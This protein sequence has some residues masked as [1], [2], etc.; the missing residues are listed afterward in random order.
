LGRGAG[1]GQGSI[2]HTETYWEGRAGF[3]SAH[4]RVFGMASISI[5]IITHISIGFL[6]GMMLAGFMVG[7]CVAP[8]VEIYDRQWT[9]VCLG[10][11]GG[12]A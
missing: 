2:L 7:W 1:E 11:E 3:I 6:M 4:R 10:R 12:G 9:C 5:T 8:D